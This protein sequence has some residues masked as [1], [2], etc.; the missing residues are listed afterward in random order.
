[1]SNAVRAAFWSIAFERDTETSTI[2][3]SGVTAKVS[4]VLLPV[5]VIEST[6]D[7]NFTVGPV[8]WP[9]SCSNHGQSCLKMPKLT[10]V[11]PA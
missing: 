1:V 11:K 3:A 10:G 2:K 5:T 6:Y 4:P 9:V 7:T 8:S